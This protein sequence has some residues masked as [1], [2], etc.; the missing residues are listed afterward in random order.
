MSRCFELSIRTRL[1]LLRAYPCRTGN[2]FGH[3]CVTFMLMELSHATTNYYLVMCH[4]NSE[5]EFDAMRMGERRQVCLEAF[6]IATDISASHSKKSLP[7]EH[8]DRARPC[9]RSRKIRT[10]LVSYNCATIS[11]VIIVIT[12]MR[13]RTALQRVN[14]YAI[15]H[16][17]N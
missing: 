17:N 9:E 16:W 4:A 7:I 6:E 3:C 15:R 8:V 2:E 12:A 11:R 1:A 13:T 5:L 10:V 14:R